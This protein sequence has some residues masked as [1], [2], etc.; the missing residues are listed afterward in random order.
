MEARL[1]RE[2]LQ[3]CHRGE[4]VN[5]YANCKELAERYTDMIRDN[6]VG[7]VSSIGPWSTARPR[8]MQQR[9]SGHAGEASRSLLIACV[10][11]LA[12]QSYRLIAFGRGCTLSGCLPAM[13]DN[14]RRCVGDL[15]A[16][17]RGP[18]AVVMPTCASTS[19]TAGDPPALIVV[20]S[21]APLFTVSN[22]FADASADPRLQDH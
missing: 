19:D 15:D 6:K 3:K 11:C 7:S 16:L 8:C 13:L 2:E 20:C 10:P 9:W 1:V 21:P 22:T 17:V 14:G 12:R 4:G 18:A 5:H